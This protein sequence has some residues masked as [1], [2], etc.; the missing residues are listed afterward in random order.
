MVRNVQ[1][2]ANACNI[3]H[4]KKSI[5]TQKQN[6]LYLIRQIKYL[7]NLKILHVRTMNV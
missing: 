1:Y 4:L 6:L 3:K 5:P 2:T 7:F